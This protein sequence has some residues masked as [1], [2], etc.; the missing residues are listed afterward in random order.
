MTVG[1]PRL[2]VIS[3]A[4]EIWGITITPIMHESMAATRGNP[5]R[6]VAFICWLSSHWFTI[7]KVGR[8]WWNLDSMQ[9]TPAV[10]TETY[11]TMLLHQLQHEKYTIFV[12]RGNVPEHAVESPGA[13]H[14]GGFVEWGW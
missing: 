4:L 1:V 2:Q 10:V 7:R 5:L 14:A 3:K 8:Q 12:C 9:A 13:G 11:L 6:E